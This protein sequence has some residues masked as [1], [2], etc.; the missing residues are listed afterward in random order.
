MDGRLYRG[1]ETVTLSI[2]AA[3]PAAYFVRAGCVLPTDEAP[4]GFRKAPE[5]VLTVC[6]VKEGSFTAEFFDD[7]GE[8]FG[9][10]ENCCVRLQITVRCTK[11]HV[12]VRYKNTGEQPF[13]PVFRLMRGD[14]RAL[15]IEPQKGETP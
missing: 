1:G 12:T 3:G 8:S 5:L 11:T 13:A 14:A 15:Q 9:Y 4:Y 10:L 2:P 6:P 7:D